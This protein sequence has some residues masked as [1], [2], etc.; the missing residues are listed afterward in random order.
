MRCSMLNPVAAGMVA[1]TSPALAR[2]VTL[3]KF[4]AITDLLTACT[5]NGGGSLQGLHGRDLDLHPRAPVLLGVQRVGDRVDYL[6]VVV[7]DP[8]LGRRVA[9]NLEHVVG[10]GL[11]RSPHQPLRVGLALESLGPGLHRSHHDL[12]RAIQGWGSLPAPSQH[13]DGVVGPLSRS[14]RCVRPSDG[15]AGPALAYGLAGD[16]APV[17]HPHRLSSSHRASCSR[18]SRRDRAC[19]CPRRLRASTAP[20]MPITLSSASTWSMPAIASSRCVML[21]TMDIR[22][23]LRPD[24]VMTLTASPGPRRHRSGD[25]GPSRTTRAG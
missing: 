19:I 25:S 21:A 4:Q 7:P 9:Q 5:G 10:V 8:R 1:N 18:A 14:L 22:R 12:D 13:P 2:F 15:D 3:S 16:D 20:V 11:V 6:R 24:G 23:A 17:Q